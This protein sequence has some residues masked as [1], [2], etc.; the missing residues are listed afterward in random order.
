MLKSVSPGVVSTTAYLSVSRT[1]SKGTVCMLLPGRLRCKLH[2]GRKNSPATRYLA[3]EFQSWL[4]IRAGSRFDRF[5]YDSRIDV[6]DIAK[7]LARTIASLQN[8]PG[9]NSSLQ[10]ASNVLSIGRSFSSE[11]I[12]N[13][14]RSDVL[15]IFYY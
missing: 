7:K 12:E 8:S 13:R 15:N 6:G 5:I 3:R 1:P 9:R 11:A 4:P 14:N 10:P 2:P